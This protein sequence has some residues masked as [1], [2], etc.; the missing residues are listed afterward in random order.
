MRESKVSLS[1]TFLFRRCA[2]K[3]CVRNNVQELINHAIL[4]LF[5]AAKK[6]M[7]RLYRILL[8]IIGYSPTFGQVTFDQLPR[9]LQLYPR[10]AANQ[11]EVPVGGQITTAGWT[12]IGM[13]VLR[14]GKISQVISQTVDPAAT[15]TAFQFK[16]QIKAEPAEYLVRVFL[17]KNNDSTSVATRSRIVSGDVYIIDGQSNAAAGAGLDEFYSF[18]FDDKY[19]R[20]CT[21]PYN[22]ANIPADM[23]WYPAKEPY[24]SVGGFG[25]TLQRLILQTYGIPT[26]V[27]NGAVG[28][29]SIVGL[30][31]RDA[32]NPVNLGTFYGQLLF[33]AQW[34]GVAKQ[35]KA[36]IWKQGEYEAGSGADLSNYEVR[37]KEFLTNLRTDY[38]PDARIYVGQ[39]NILPGEVK[40]EAAAALR[41]Y[42]RRTKY[43]FKNVETIAT[44]GTP[45]LGFDGVHYE[46]KS[47]QQLAFE[48]FRQIARDVYGSKDTLQIN[49]PDIKKVFYNA[50]KDTL[51]LVFDEG[52]QM[53]YKADTAFYNFATGAKVYTRELKDFFYLDGQAGGVSG[54]STN[55]NRVILNLKQP[56]S[57]KTLRYLPAYFSD[58]YSSFYDGPT[59]RNTRGMRAFSFDNVLIADA[60]AAVTTLAARPV[61]EKQIQ[62]NWTASATAGTQYLE[63]A[64]DTPASYKRIATLNGSAATYTD[65][66]LPNPLGTY[67]YRLRAVNDASE[68]G[69]SNV[70]SARPLV[71]SAEPAESL[72]WVYPNPLSADRTLYVEAEQTTFTGVTVRDLLGRAVKSWTGAARNTIAIAL[73]TVEAGVYVAILQTADGLVLRRKLVVR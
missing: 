15:N 37:F 59:L 48:Q 13:Q 8:L 67:Y 66:N 73:D 12:K 57:A 5:L 43:L 51:T 10:N 41:D 38:N 72:V 34:A 44:V 36:L 61:S 53:V 33:R 23:Q 26:V 62:L 24:A 18:N 17:Y 42:Q 9:N 52:M 49:S 39:I 54:G 71:L 70:V 28:G 6:L 58:A 64:D 27:L 45:G 46:A 14:E 69:Y 7:E 68:S 22:S 2:E 31:A 56:A 1:E 4:Y 55:G 60:I 65:D 11:A 19:L 63:R 21:F 40:I 29:T 16:A 32:V 35:V 47:H 30:T 3:S 25:L 50:R 20:N